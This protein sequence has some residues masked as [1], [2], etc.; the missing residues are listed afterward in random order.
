MPKTTHLVSGVSESKPLVFS[1]RAELSLEEHW[2]EG[3]SRNMRDASSRC[4]RNS[5]YIFTVAISD[6]RRN[7]VGFL[8]M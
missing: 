3:S 5:L 8:M 6:L 7:V 1:H 4:L 2:L